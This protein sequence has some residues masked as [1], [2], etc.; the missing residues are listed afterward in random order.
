MPIPLFPLLDPIPVYNVD[1]TMNKEG[2]ITQ[3]AH[4]EIEIEERKR[5]YEFLATALGKQRLILGLPWLEE[6][7]PLIDWKE[8]KISW[9]NRG[10]TIYAIS[11]IIESSD[12]ELVI[13]FIGNKLMEKAKED[14]VKTKMS[15]SQLFAG[16]DRPEDEKAATELVLKE[17]HNFLDMVFTKR[18]IGVLLKR[19]PFDHKIELKPGFKPQ[20]GPL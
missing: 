2:H 13:S 7:N 15:H 12:E 16:Q 5:I 3:Y 11:P 4:L 8:R 10:E 19:R 17:C 14:W 9:R 18:E 20:I 1:G 6:E